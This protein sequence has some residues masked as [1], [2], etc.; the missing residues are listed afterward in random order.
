MK[1]REGETKEETTG[2]EIEGV[3]HWLVGVVTRKKLETEAT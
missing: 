2:G 3:K 1:H